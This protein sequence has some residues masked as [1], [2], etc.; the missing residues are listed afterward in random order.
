MQT[1][2][3]RGSKSSSAVRLHQS[4]R[5]L[6]PGVGPVPFPVHWAGCWGSA[7]GASGKVT[8]HSANL[9]TKNKTSAPLGSGDIYPQYWTPSIGG[10][11]MK[12][13]YEYKK[14]CVELYR[15]GKWAETPEGVSTDR[16]HHAVV[17]WNRLEKTCGPEILQHTERPL[18]KW[19][20]D[21]SQ[22]DLSWGKCYIFPILDMNM[23]EIIS[24]NLSNSPYME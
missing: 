17:E 4:G 23:N 21:V 5:G 24:Y 8:E 13:S 20:T 14:H 1:Y 3:A 10:N 9:R 11:F 2:S 19:T 7:D 22:F 15:Q 12:Y 6:L 16:F 18:Q